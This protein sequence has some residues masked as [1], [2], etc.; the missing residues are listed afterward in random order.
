MMRMSVAMEE[1]RREMEMWERERR[2]WWEERYEED[3]RRRAQ[4]R[5]NQKEYVEERQRYEK[6]R[7]IYEERRR[8][9]EKERREQEESLL[10]K[11]RQE[12]ERM[13]QEHEAEARRQAEKSNEFQ[14]KYAMDFMKEL[15]KRD[16]E[17]AK[18][19]ENDKLNDTM[20]LQYITKDRKHREN[21]VWLKKRHEQEM[22]EVNREFYG[23]PEEAQRKREELKRRHEGEVQ[24][25]IRDRVDRAVDNQACAIL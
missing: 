20:R 9:E 10:K 16:L 7:Q 4:E 19:R 8:E 25:W 15:K 5:E 23:R 24:L 11:H 22:K 12:L 1:M 18:L 2:E 13:R 6:E 17:L 21:Y 14:Q 3:E